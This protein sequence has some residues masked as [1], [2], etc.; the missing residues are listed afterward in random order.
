MPVS[1]LRHLVPVRADA[2]LHTL[3]F[4]IFSM[5]ILLPDNSVV[6]GDGNY[7]EPGRG[8][9]ERRAIMDAARVPVSRE[10]GLPVIFVVDI[11]RSDGHRAYLQAKPVNPDSSPLDWNNTPFAEEWRA[12]MM[13]DVVMILLERVNGRWIA[14]DYFI[15]PTDVAW[16]GWLEKYNLPE[17]LFAGD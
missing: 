11:L 8:S 2:F 12:D 10:T 9:Q 7:Y 16:Y 13:S 1:T 14:R 3:A 6:A 17:A 15:G 5:L 4:L